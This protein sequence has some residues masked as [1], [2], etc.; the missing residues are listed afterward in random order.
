MENPTMP[1]KF[2]ILT[3]LIEALAE[4]SEKLSLLWH[5]VGRMYMYV[6]LSYGVT[7]FLMA[8]VLN[9]TLVIAL[10]NNL[11][12]QQLRARGLVS[13]GS[14]RAL[15][16]SLCVIA[17]RVGIV[18]QLAY[19]LF[20]VMVA[21]NVH[22]HLISKHS[23]WLASLLPDLIFSY[24]VDRYASSRYM[25]TPR[26]QV[27]IGPT[28]DMNWPIFLNI[29]LLLFVESFV[30]VIQGKQPF[31]ETGISMLELSMMFQE[32]SGGA[33][34]FLG[35]F[36]L[37]E[38]SENP[39]YYYNRPTEQV[40]VITALLLLS[41]MNIHIFAVIN[42]NRYRLI[43]TTILGLS[44]LAYFAV[45]I[46]QGFLLDL[47]L[48]LIATVVPQLVIVC[49]ILVCVG[50]FA[51]AMIF[52]G[53]LRDPSVLALFSLENE[54]LFGWGDD[55]YTAL[56][57]L[58]TLA[59]LLAGKS[60]YTKEIST[61]TLNKTTWVDVKRGY[62]NLITYPVE[63]EEEEPNKLSKKY[64]GLGKV[65]G[66]FGELLACLVK[67]A[68]TRNRPKQVPSFLSKYTKVELP[69]Q[70]SLKELTVE[71][72]GDQYVQL[73]TGVDLDENDESQDFVPGGLVEAEEDSEVES[74]VEVPTTGINELL[75]AQEFTDLIKSP[76][77]AVLKRRMASD[78]RI[79]RSMFKSS[80]NESIRLKQIIEA[81][82][83]AE[84][85]DDKFDCVICHCNTREII[86][87][88]C[89]CFAICESCRITL[90]AKGIEGCVCCRGPVEGVSK[91]FIP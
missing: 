4:Q 16:R 27:M 52:N 70:V 34:L 31:T 45:Y 21:L 61:V 66:Q 2:T 68:F 89:R 59:I 73:L 91:V 30:L 6:C 56:I 24:D 77:M 76:S 41:H 49:V 47:P 23:G 19:N 60:S 14:K 84:D 54:Q 12:L 17:F 87:W 5:R 53:D 65:T 20:Q 32:F 1:S 7:C 64:K 3:Q 50:I 33:G 83:M 35:R 44:L 71:Q 62:D 18:V 57:N 29:C 22:S 75:D 25:R 67:N 28:T 26:R 43:P 11:R 38:T 88:P 79:T 82:R 13:L 58:G 51:A 15:L 90:V 72:V 10:T 63:E 46:W 37:S 42:D 74:D 39:S 80:D 40:L 86:T 69:L 9:R 48:I 8:L 55:F 36:K 81:E 85:F 78:R